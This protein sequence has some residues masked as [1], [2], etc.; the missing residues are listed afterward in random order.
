MPNAKF[1]MMNRSKRIGGIGENRISRIAMTQTTRN[2][3]LFF[4]RMSLNILRADLG[5][6]TFVPD[7]RV[8]AGHQAVEGLGDLAV[9]CAPVEAAGEGRV[10]NDHHAV[11]ER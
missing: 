3:S 7:V 4:P 10:L 11:E 6:L 9:E 5:W 2:R 1:T 8:D